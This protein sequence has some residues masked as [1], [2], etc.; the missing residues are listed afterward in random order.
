MLFPGCKQQLKLKLI[1]ITLLE[2]NMYNCN[3]FPGDIKVRAIFFNDKVSYELVYVA[4]LTMISTLI[5][6][7][8]GSLNCNFFSFIYSLYIA[9]KELEDESERMFLLLQFS[10]LNKESKT[11]K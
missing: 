6:G 4:N 1:R 8:K 7:V 9:L 2:K 10:M 11:K 3:K 5:L